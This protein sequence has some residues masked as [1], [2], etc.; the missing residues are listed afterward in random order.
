MR[1]ARE[2]LVPN[3]TVHAVPVTEPPVTYFPRLV[4]G[5]RTIPTVLSIRSGEG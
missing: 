1:L 5:H 4:T 3:D 2:L